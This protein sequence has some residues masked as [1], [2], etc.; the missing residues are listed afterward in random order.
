MDVRSTNQIRQHNSII[1]IQSAFR[2]YK[3]RTKVKFFSKLP[4]DLWEYI[5]E[6]L[7]KEAILQTLINKFIL[8]KMIRFYWSP[9]GIRIKSKM[10]ALYMV[11]KYIHFLKRDT[12][13]KAQSLCFKLLNYTSDFKQ[14][15]L[16]N[17]TLEMILIKLFPN[18]PNYNS[19]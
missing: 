3:C 9:I 14:R 1:I 8:L 16:V 12:L 19:A 17:A 13:I 4:T 18:H 6:F 10:Y 2:S 11:R 5:V 7:K 15:L